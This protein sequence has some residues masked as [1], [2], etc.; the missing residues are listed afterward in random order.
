MRSGTGFLPTAFASNRSRTACDPQLLVTSTG[1][2]SRGRQGW[3][4][5]HGL[6]CAPPRVPVSFPPC[7]AHEKISST[8]AKIPTIF[9]VVLSLPL[10]GATAAHR[11]RAFLLCRPRTFRS[12]DSKWALTLV[13]WSVRGSG[14]FVLSESLGKAWSPHPSFSLSP[15]RV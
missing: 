11:H 8:C 1:R 10:L 4:H 15:C 7:D 5:P 14:S 12:L 2:R 3:S 13:F 9:G 6:V